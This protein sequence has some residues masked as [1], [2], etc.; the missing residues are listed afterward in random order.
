MGLESGEALLRAFEKHTKQVRQVYEGVTD[1]LA[2]ILGVSEQLMLSLSVAGGLETDESAFLS[3]NFARPKEAQKRLS[4]LV[5]GEATVG[6]R[7]REQ[8]RVMKVLPALLNATAR[9]PGKR[10]SRL[11]HGE[12]TVGLRWREQVRVMKVLPAL[13]NAIARTPDP[14]SALMRLEGIVDALGPR[15]SVLDSLASNLFALRALTLVASVSEPLCQLATRHPEWLEAMLSGTLAEIPDE[16]TVRSE[17][18]SSL[19]QGEWDVVARA[20]RW[21]KG[22][23]ALP[24]G[25]ASICRLSPGEKVERIL[26]KLA[27]ILVGESMRWLKKPTFGWRI[28]AMAKE[29]DWLQNRRFRSRRMGKRGTPLRLRFGCRFRSR[30]GAFRR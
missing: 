15:Y 18:A 8:V 3:L 26:S 4:R 10:L 14:D 24:L 11:V 1:E 23:F 22:K 17:V 29:A 27:D 16:E 12:A 28:N 7:W 19:L 9:T 21:L 20:V 30:R 2:K 5:H 6:L 13:L 25:F